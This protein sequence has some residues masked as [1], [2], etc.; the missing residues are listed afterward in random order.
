MHRRQFLAASAR[1]A[2]AAAVAPVVSVPV[3]A[4][5]AIAPP[6]LGASSRWASL[7]LPP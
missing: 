2:L 1:L 6:L 3:A 7:A 5:D 4:A